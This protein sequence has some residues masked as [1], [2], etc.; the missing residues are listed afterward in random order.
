M[1]LNVLAVGCGGFIGAVCRYLCTTLTNKI[2]YLTINA[3]SFGFPIGILM[4]NFVGCFLMGL[5][6][7]VLPAH[8][9]GNTRLLG[10]ATTGCIGG[11]TTMS[12]FC[13]DSLKLFVGGDY[14]LCILNVTLTFVLCMVGVAAGVACGKALS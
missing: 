2:A 13:L 14:V 9:S 3:P 1:F 5:L 6:A 7:M 11:F 10:F 12:T 4:I 8:F